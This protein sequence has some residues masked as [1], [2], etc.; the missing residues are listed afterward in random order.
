MRLTEDSWGEHAFSNLNQLVPMRSHHYPR[1]SFHAALLLH[2]PGLVLPLSMPLPMNLAVRY[3]R[4]AETLMRTERT[5]EAFASLN[6][7][8][9]GT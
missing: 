1:L 3:H 8:G 6:V 9:V 5:S 2:N 4:T 7:N